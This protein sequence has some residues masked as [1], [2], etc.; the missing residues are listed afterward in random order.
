MMRFLGTGAAEGIP[1]PFCRCRVCENARKIGGKEIRMR[2]CFR[3]SED[4]LIDFGTDLFSECIRSGTDLY[5][6]K[7]VLI[8][9]THEDHF[10]LGNLFLKP[11]ISRGNGQKIQLWFTGDGFGLLEALDRMKYDGKEAF[12][13]EQMEKDYETHRMEFFQTYEIGPYQ[14]TPVKGEHPAHMEKNAANYLIRLPDGTVMLYALDTG[15]YE[16]QTLAYLKGV[17]IDTLI[18][19]CTFGSLDRGDKPYSHMDLRSSLYLCETLYAQGTIGK[20][21]KVY[22]THINQ[23]QEY[24]HEELSQECARRTK[25]LPYEVTVA[26]DGLSIRKEEGNAFTKA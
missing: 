24:T 10:D 11:M 18:A 21:T 26:Y 5:D 6:L 12:F 4:M 20:E 9:H 1:T 8:T 13:K 16:A 7:Y 17:K 23:E 2:S 25:G 22:L 15:Y 3:V 14:V 19:E